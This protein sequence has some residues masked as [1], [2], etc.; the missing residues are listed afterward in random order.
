MRPRLRLS[1]ADLD[2]IVTASVRAFPEECCGLLLGAREASGV[3]VE[4]ILAAAN[5]APDRARRFEVEPRT[6]IAA[7]KAAREAGL[8]VIGHYHSHPGGGAAPS[9]HD[10]ARA[11]ADGEV[12]LIVPVTDGGAGTPAAHLYTAGQFEAMEIAAPL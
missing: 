11:Y 8:E 7:H 2:A 9:A 6:L 1:A 12:W 5:I 10:R 4:S 3:T